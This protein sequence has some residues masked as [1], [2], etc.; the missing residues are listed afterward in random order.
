MKIEAGQLLDV[1][2]SDLANGTF[3]FPLTVNEISFN[4]FK[5]CNELKHIEIPKTIDKIQF[6]AFEGCQNLEK[7]KFDKGLRYLAQ[8]I[9]KNCTNLKFVSL[10]PSL[11]RVS[12]SAFEGCKNLK[13]I[14]IPNGV[15]YIENFAFLGCENLKKVNIPF[16]TRLIDSS[17]FSD[18]TSLKSIKIH[19]STNEL[20]NYAFN[21]CTNLSSV[22]L[23]SEVKHILKSCFGNCTSLKRI[24][25]PS[26]LLSL[27]EYAFYNCKNLGSIKIPDKI[28]E[29]KPFTFS[30]CSSLSKVK[31]NDK[32]SKIS[33]NAFSNCT[34]LI[35]LNFPKSLTRIGKNA[36]ANCTSLKKI[37]FLPGLLTL[38]N[39]AFANCESL[40]E[41][42]LP[43]TITTIGNNVFKNCKSLRQIMMPADLKEVGNNIFDGC[44]SLN[45]V[46]FPNSLVYFGNNNSNF[47]YFTN[48]QNSNGF[49]LSKDPDFDS[50]PLEEIKISPNIL[51]KYWD[52]KDTLLK[53]QNNANV[54]NFYNIF[55]YQLKE[56][57][58]KEF[59]NS[60]NFTFFK[61]FDLTNKN[62]K[63]LESFY[64]F[65]YNLGG[66]SEPVMVGGKKIDYAQKVGEFFLEK[67]AKTKFKIDGLFQKFETM[68]INGFNHE[69]T[70]FILNNY[71]SIIENKKLEPDFISKCYNKFDEVQ[72]TNTSNRGNQRQLKPTVEKFIDYFK[73]GKFNN[74][75]PENKAIAETLSPFTSR[76]S[77]FDNAV[78]IN[79]ERIDNKT[80]N[81]ILGVHL[82]E[83]KVPAPFENI[84]KY[85]NEIKNLEFQAIQNL[86]DI[87]ENEFTFDWL[88]KNDPD[89]F[90][91]GKLCTCCAHLEGA[92]YGIM[93]A[94]IVHPDV[95]NLVIRDKD[96]T[97]IAK[98]TLYINRKDGFGVFNNVEVNN[99]IPDYKKEQIYEKFM[100]GAKEFVLKY[101]ELNK[102]SPIKKITVGMGNNDLFEIL[103][104]KNKRSTKNLKAINYEIFGIDN[105][106]YVGDSEAYQTI[107]W[108]Q[109][110][111]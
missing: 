32:I 14:H 48:G 93:H 15:R 72:K 87:S 97:I 50:I 30:N 88:E 24:N 1:K 64:K 99:N 11:A 110:E 26:K 107:I 76:Q 34:S 20:G 21:N 103:K 47:L 77:S 25:L 29:I 96:N 71:D 91:V 19:S 42:I 69:F 28:R 40:E 89:N 45:R 79:Q 33:E 22:K 102:N 36:F 59:L 55:A 80:P 16:G 82:K 51:S 7:V 46:Y 39:G 38:S 95:Q 84:E 60:H 18:C 23:S 66:F 105:D 85:Q 56:K 3:S 17:A 35:A 8:D 27:D 41:I 94:S 53:E 62:P 49:C 98:S 104:E 43:Y 109:N 54:C 100:L 44:N 83:E 2:N 9:F 13:S 86:V 92:G 73:I 78:K 106:R 74:V 57:E 108:E 12:S 58:F 67:M 61:K 90:I 4:A 5:D 101:N 63:D 31:F 68:E 10:P 70:E 75:T 65:Y 6:S 52:Y 81:N 37:E 111:K